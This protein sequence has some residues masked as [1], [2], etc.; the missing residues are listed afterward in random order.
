MVDF[1]F[2]FQYAEAKQTALQ[3][4]AGS[5]PAGRCVVLCGGSGCGKTTLLR[6]INGLIPQFYE[7]E[8][9]GFCRLNGRDTAGMSIGEIGE[10]AASVFQD[11]RSQFFTVNSS[12]EVAFGLENHGMPQADIRRRVDEAFGVFHLERLKDRNVYELSSGE[13][14]LVSILSAWAMDT[15]IFLLDEPTANLDFAATQQLRAVLLALKQ[16]GKTLLL[17][18]HRLY[19][20]SGVADEYWVMENGA[21]AA[22]YSA[23]E[24]RGFSQEKLRGLA[25]R[26]LDLGNIAVAEK[27]A[28][29]DEGAPALCVKGLRFTYAHQARPIISDMDLS[30][31]AHEVV[32]LVGANGCG[33][34]TL[35][36]LIA[37][38]YKPAAGQ[39]TL[40]GSGRTPK[41][42]RSQVM[43][44]MQEAE[45]Q[46]F[47]NSVINELKYGHAATPE[48][49]QAAETLLRRMGMWE[50]RD[51]HPFSLSGGQMQKLTLMTAFLSEKPVIVL[52]EPTA[53]QDAESLDS[54]A[55]LIR[56]MGRE[57]TVVIITHDLELI[58]KAC[59]RCIGLE[60]GG[61]DAQLP[62]QNE[63][64]LQ[65]VRRYMEGFR[66]A[67]APPV[68]KSARERFHPATK[69]LFWLVTMI[70]VSTSDNRFAFS[71]YAA[72]LLLTA[73]D[74]WIGTALAGGGLFAA[75]WAA[76]RLMPH[77]VLSFMLVLVPRIAAVWISMKTLIGRNEAGRTL[78]ALRDIRLPERL[79][80][81]V[82]VIFR[83]FPVL[84]G[85]M[86]LLRQS[87]A[88]RGVFAAPWEKLRALPAYL[89]ILTVPMALR[90]IRI[91]E[92]LSASAET[93]GID[94]KRRKSNFL[95][96]RF[97]GLD[98]VF[99]AVLLAAMAA[100]LLL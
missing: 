18:E 97:S 93:R 75:L 11:P 79:I 84:S 92:T 78:A 77:T 66:P 17:S 47:T 48:F 43:F 60:D 59:T 22:K 32:G 1:E 8:L 86:K 68:Q 28:P 74:G 23:G 5:I 15:Q 53:G 31:R 38:L 2:E 89:E 19:Y 42:L 99:A 16:Q 9:R 96:L 24:M 54:C 21:V 20:L 88:T 82:A 63:R 73:A 98:A 45:F 37:G 67:D 100:G 3:K 14:Q 51:R 80:M 90:V 34:T 49:D 57:K 55:A 94:L 81:I 25:L 35:G 83:F 6:C 61:A 64:E 13:R 36:K 39:I 44:I 46:F 29:A 4:A 58:A 91:A 33:K 69:L 41:Q 95:S 30:V 85:D 65:D 87:V 62:V 56:E 12:N 26:T 50:C 72:L 7:G 70:A 27:P 76:A 52:D 71:V 10:L 40:F